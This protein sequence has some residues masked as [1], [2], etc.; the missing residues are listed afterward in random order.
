MKALAR[1]LEHQQA[2]PLG[3]ESSLQ[4]EAAPDQDERD[5][6]DEAGRDPRREG[7]RPAK[8]HHGAD[9]TRGAAGLTSRGASDKLRA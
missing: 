4:P 6:D 7:G 9:Y 5:D 2:Q 8:A 1:P 3:R